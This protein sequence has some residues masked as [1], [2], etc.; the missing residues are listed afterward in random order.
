[1]HRTFLGLQLLAAVASAFVVVWFRL[2]ELLTPQSA[3]LD[4]L[5]EAALA[6]IVLL[7]L[8]MVAISR[9]AFSSHGFGIAVRVGILA[10]TVLS[11]FGPHIL[12]APR[13]AALEA[14][15]LADERR[16]DEAFLREVETWRMTIDHDAAAARPLT[17]EQAWE[18][19]DLVSRAGYCNDPP[20]AQALALL[21]QA[22]AAKIL[23]VNVMV[24]GRRRSDTAPR[25]LFLQFYKERVEPL[26]RIRALPAQDWAIMK[27]LAANGADLTL[28]DAAPLV[29]DLART[30]VSGPWRYIGLQ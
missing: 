11:G 2:Q 3:E 29:A 24:Q 9:L 10:L 30:E 15:H 1:M 13:K 25:P 17:A 23:D 28:P 19:I 7:S 4:H 21:R 16:L 18:F 5:A 26:G 14:A 20:P 22:L 12:R 27:S 6:A 8:A